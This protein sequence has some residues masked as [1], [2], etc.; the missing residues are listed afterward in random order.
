MEGGIQLKKIILGLDKGLSKAGEWFLYSKAFENFI[1]S[2]LMLI[3]T[4]ILLLVTS[5][6]FF[7]VRSLAQFL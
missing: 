6:L 5:W 7:Q 4:A 3:T 2:L 1:N